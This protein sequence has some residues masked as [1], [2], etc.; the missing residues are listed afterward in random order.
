MA[1]RVPPSSRPADSTSNRQTGSTN[2]PECE[3]GKRRPAGTRGCALHR[4]PRCFRRFTLPLFRRFAN[5]T[6]LA[7]ADR[8]P[9]KEACMI[10]LDLSG[11]IALV[12]G[13]G[14]NMSFAWHIA[15]GLQAAGAR[16]VFGVHPRFVRIVEGFLEGDSPEDVQSRLLPHGAG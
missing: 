3:R 15:K 10:S 5:H 13:V 7:L 1:P 12:T 14:D 16:L 9:R 2:R 6:R 4:W 11:K 8:K